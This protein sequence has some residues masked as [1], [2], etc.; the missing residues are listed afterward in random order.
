[1]PAEHKF[2]SFKSGTQSAKN[3]TL[4]VLSTLSMVLEGLPIP[5]AKASV[6]I[7]VDFIKA[8]DVS[9]A[10]DYVYDQTLM[11]MLPA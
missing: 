2:F 11:F 5:G 3:A 9:D 4:D 10:V 1:M 7:L 6:A 8:V